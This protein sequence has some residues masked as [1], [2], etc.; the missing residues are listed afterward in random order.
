MKSE[1][2]EVSLVVEGGDLSANEVWLLWEKSCEQ[3]ADGV[4]QT[5]GE[6]VEDHLW[7]VFS[8]IFA[9][10]LSNKEKEPDDL[11]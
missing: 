10:S 2:D 11:K 9:S 5:S 6:I 1:K 3:T 7:V 8:W 4:P